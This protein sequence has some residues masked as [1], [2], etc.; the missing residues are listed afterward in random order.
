MTC[1]TQELNNI[2]IFILASLLLSTILFCAV[3]IFSYNSKVNP[4]TSSAYESGFQPFSET[5]YPFSVQ[6]SLIAILFLLFDIEVLYLYP[7]VTS[8]DDL[9]YNSLISLV[10]FFL[11]LLLGIVYEISRQVMSM[12]VTNSSN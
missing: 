12:G 3:Y 8:I 10:F 4:E 7:L 2:G 6:F 5:S 1:F 11:I 9:P